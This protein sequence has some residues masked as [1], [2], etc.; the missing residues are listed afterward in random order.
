M[1]HIHAP[2]KL[3]WGSHGRS[4]RA[5]RIIDA[6]GKPVAAFGNQVRWQGITQIVAR[7]KLLVAAPSLLEA[8][9]AEEAFW[10]HYDAC[11]RCSKT[12]FCQDALWLMVTARGLRLRAIDK[13][14]NEREEYENG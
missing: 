3:V 7:A 14:N 5:P 12:T 2:W 6:L 8:C 13:V 9:E 10:K 4:V 11:P 1:D